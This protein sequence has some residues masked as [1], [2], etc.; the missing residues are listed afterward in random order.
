MINYLYDSIDCINQKMKSK[1]FWIFS[2]YICNIIVHSL[3]ENS[4]IKVPDFRWNK[5][6]CTPGYNYWSNDLNDLIY[7]DVKILISIF[8]LNFILVLIIF[9]LIICNL[10]KSISCST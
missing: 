3:V 2:L 8:I 10:K 5:T 6:T 9:I 4:N 1:L 7:P